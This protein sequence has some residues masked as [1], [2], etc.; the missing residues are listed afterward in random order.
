MK[1]LF[2]TI[3]LM[4]CMFFTVSASAQINWGVKGGLN[5]SS[6]TGYSDLLGMEEDG[7][8]VTF[9]SKYKP[10]FHLG[11]MGQ[12]NLPVPNLFVQPEL[13]Y[14][15]QGVKLEWEVADYSDSNTTNLHYLQLPV[16]LGYKINAGLGLDVVLGVGPFIGYGVGGDDDFF[17]SN[18]RFDFGF[19]AMAGIEFSRFQITLGYDLGV[20]NTDDSSSD[21]SSYNRNAKVS[22][23]YFF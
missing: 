9:D 17:D 13:L 7:S 20:I 14:S 3:A 15:M 23:G 19:A 12:I 4:V 16:Y 11:V 8:I 18:K 1:N 22:V 21:F 6:L 5:V 10:G 2:K